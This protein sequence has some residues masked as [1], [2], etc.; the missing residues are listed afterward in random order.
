LIATITIGFF[1]GWPG[2]S[3]ASD[4]D[5]AGFGGWVVEIADVLEACCFFWKLILQGKWE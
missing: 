1:V 4:S 5:A 3:D 2:F